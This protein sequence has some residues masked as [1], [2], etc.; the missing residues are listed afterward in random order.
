M[1]SSDVR[2]RRPG[3]GTT[4]DRIL[5]GAGQAFGEKGYAAT[6]V[7][8]IL[9]AAGLSRPTFYKVFDSKEHVF[10]ALSERHHRTIFERLTGASVGAEDPFERLDRWTEVFFRWRIELG[11]V[12][13]VLDAEA[14]SPLSDLREHRALVLDT[15]IDGLVASFVSDG[16]P[17]PD[18]QLLYA[19]IAAVE[20]LADSLIEEPEPRQEAFQH[21]LCLVRQ[22][23][24]RQ[25]R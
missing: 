16:R 15:L 6:R 25:L 20:R 21:R 8:D 7:E 13:R 1:L 14:R 18:R 24:E 12:G 3:Q 9:R 17:A 11:P 19:L 5:R 2:G 23:F 4:R 10:R 22:L